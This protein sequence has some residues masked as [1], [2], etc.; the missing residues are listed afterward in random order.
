M[1]AKSLQSCLTLCD[2]VDCSLLGSSVQ[3]DSAKFCPDSMKDM[4]IQNRLKENSKILLTKS[5]SISSC[6]KSQAFLSLFNKNSNQVKYR[7]FTT[8]PFYLLLH[9]CTG[10]INDDSRNWLGFGALVGQLF[11]VRKQL[12]EH[13]HTHTV[14]GPYSSTQTPT[15]I[16][17]PLPHSPNERLLW[18]LVTEP[19]EEMPSLT[20]FSK[21][22]TCGGFI[23]IFGK[24]NTV[25]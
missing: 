19:L 11:D 1:H 10:F 4:H 2:L 6:L 7:K 12:G 20:C 23:L 17:Q 21:I 18:E 24:T 15:H 8:S 13:T 22:Y 14:P 16:Y 5:G 25:M 9:L 3:M